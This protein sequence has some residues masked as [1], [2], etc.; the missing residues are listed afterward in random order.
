MTTNSRDD[1]RAVLDTIETFLDTC[2]GVEDLD[3][4]FNR[5]APEGVDFETIYDGEVLY[6]TIDGRHYKAAVMGVEG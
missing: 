2:P 5:D 1:K 3:L 6:L 4:T